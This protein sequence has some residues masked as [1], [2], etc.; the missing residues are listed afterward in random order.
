M[1]FI[2]IF[3]PSKM[4]HEAVRDKICRIPLS[5]KGLVAPYLL[6]AGTAVFVSIFSLDTAIWLFVI[7][8][9]VLVNLYRMSRKRQIEKP[10]EQEALPSE[11]TGTTEAS[12]IDQSGAVSR[13]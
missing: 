2:W 3:L 10:S 7:G 6:L 8:N 5:W 12:G 11:E 1:P 4:L 13:R 9:A